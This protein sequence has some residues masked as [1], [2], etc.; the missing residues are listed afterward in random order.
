MLLKTVAAGILL[1]L[2]VYQENEKLSNTGLAQ[3]K[4]EGGEVQPRTN[5][6][7]R[8]IVGGGEGLL[9]ELSLSIYQK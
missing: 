8:N 2:E 1:S 7:T 5:L 9:R 6:V 3:I 4:T